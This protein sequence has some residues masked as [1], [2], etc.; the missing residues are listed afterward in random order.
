[1][2]TNSSAPLVGS[3]ANSILYALELLAVIRYYSVSKHKQD[4]LLFQAM[5]YFTFVVDTVSTVLIYAT[6]YLV[7]N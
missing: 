3:Y 4:S 2:S 5:I 6:V 1:M 7:C